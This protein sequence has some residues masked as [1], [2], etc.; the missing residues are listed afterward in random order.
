MMEIIIISC[1]KLAYFY[2]TY[3]LKSKSHVIDIYLI[4]LLS[5]T[6]VSK[7]LRMMITQYNNNDFAITI[8][9]KS[10]GKLI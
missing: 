10:G 4:I 8:F 9:L 7:C 5:V 1:N 6:V 3:G 2:Y